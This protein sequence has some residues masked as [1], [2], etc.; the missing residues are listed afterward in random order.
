MVVML[1]VE[2]WEETGSPG[3][4]AAKAPLNHFL[5]GVPKGL[6]GVHWSLQRLLLEAGQQETAVQGEGVQVGAPGVI[7][8]SLRRAQAVGKNIR[9]H[10]SAEAST[11]AW[12]W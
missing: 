6:A 9:G 2:S 8:L 1:R 12:G 10:L 3:G 5:W 11:P 7:T 4:H